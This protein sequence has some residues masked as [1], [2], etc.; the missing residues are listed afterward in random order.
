[1]IVSDGMTKWTFYYRQY[2]RCWNIKYGL[3]PW[4]EKSEGLTM[5]YCS[6]TS[7][8][9]GRVASTMQ[10]IPPIF[11]QLPLYVMDDLPVYHC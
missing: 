10:R 7:R 1:M 5:P 4:Q 9:G 2:C 8:Y 3:E 11:E 6:R